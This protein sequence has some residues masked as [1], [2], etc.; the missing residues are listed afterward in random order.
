M[1]S[2]CTLTQSLKHRFLFVGLPTLFLL[3]SSGRAC[4]SHK[5]ISLA[6]VVKPPEPQAKDGVTPLKGGIRLAAQLFEVA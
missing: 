2:E 6:G 1:Q 5:E 4:M 3:E